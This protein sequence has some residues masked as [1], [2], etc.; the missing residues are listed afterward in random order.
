MNNRVQ[1]QL[2]YHAA[3]FRSGDFKMGELEYIG[4]TFLTLILSWVGVCGGGYGLWIR[5]LWVCVEGV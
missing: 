5:G 1:S 3:L 4:V 2:N